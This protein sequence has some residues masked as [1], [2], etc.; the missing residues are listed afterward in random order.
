[1]LAR[2]SESTVAVK[3]ITYG[4]RILARKANSADLAMPR[5]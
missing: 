4:V 3:A 2:L 5:L 1:M